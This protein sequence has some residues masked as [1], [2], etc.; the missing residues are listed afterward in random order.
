MDVRS[1]NRDSTIG[2]FEGFAE[3]IVAFFSSRFALLVMTIVIAIC[4]SSFAFDYGLNFDTRYGVL[5]GV[6]LAA[7]TFH[8]AKHL[9]DEVLAFFRGWTIVGL[10]L[11]T[12]FVSAAAWVAKA[13]QKADP[14]H[15]AL[16]DSVASL[17]SQISAKN[18]E[19]AALMASGN[20]VNA[21]EVGNQKFELEQILIAKRDEYEASSRGMGLYQ[22]G[23]MAIFGHLS[24]VSGLEQEAINLIIMFYVL[25]VLITMEI[26]MGAAATT[27]LP[28][29]K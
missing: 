2:K 14:H 3:G 9:P 15:D 19:I 5:F 24:T 6:A 23:A 22:S 13:T 28:E 29:G 27:V 7:L 12:L 10:V 26:S 11:L 18:L 25:S 20:P 8:F 1:Y 4:S 16:S 17:E 21:K